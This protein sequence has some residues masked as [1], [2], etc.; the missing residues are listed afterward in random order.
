[1]PCRGGYMGRVLSLFL[2]VCIGV[3]C[4][5]IAPL[6]AFAAQSVFYDDFPGSPLVQKKRLTGQGLEEADT[7]HAFLSGREMPATMLQ[8]D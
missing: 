4:L 8:E 1:M 3:M 2:R 5:F 6:S 7:S